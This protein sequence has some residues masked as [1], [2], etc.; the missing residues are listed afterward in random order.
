MLQENVLERQ[1]MSKVLGKQHSN[2]TN[3]H[4]TAKYKRALTIISAWPVSTSWIMLPTKKENMHI[5]DYKMLH[6]NR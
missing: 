3:G 6:V 5:K 2:I 4:L 1:L